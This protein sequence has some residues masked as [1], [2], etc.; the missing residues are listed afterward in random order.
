MLAAAAGS[1]ES[2]K[3]QGPR[4]RE[5]SNQQDRCS[6]KVKTGDEHSRKRSRSDKTTDRPEKPGNVGIGSATGP[7]FAEG[8][9][10]ERE[11]FRREGEDQPHKVVKRGPMQGRRQV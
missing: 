9:T 2:G 11:N 7:P 4:G 5:N 8:N 1:P 10:G 3:A 6:G